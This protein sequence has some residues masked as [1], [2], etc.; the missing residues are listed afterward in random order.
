[1]AAVRFGETSTALLLGVPPLLGPLLTGPVPPWSARLV[2]HWP[3]VAAALVTPFVIGAVFLRVPVLPASAVEV[4][5]AG[6]P[7]HVMRGQL[8]TVDDTS[9]TLLKS[10]GDVDFIPD[11]DVQSRIICPSV[12]RAPDSRVSVRGWPV[13]ASALSWVAPTRP[14]TAV[15]PRCLGR[16]LK[17]R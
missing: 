11:N 14:V 8:V 15:D 1:V 9:T 17:P 6:G 5:P 12:P 4:G 10:S 7:L 16:P 3:A 13:E 2:T